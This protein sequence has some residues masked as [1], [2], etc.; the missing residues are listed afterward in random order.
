[1]SATAIAA[2]PTGVANMMEPIDFTAYICLT[3]GATSLPVYGLGRAASRVRAG[4]HMDVRESR[5]TLENLTGGLNHHRRLVDE[6]CL[7]RDALRQRYLPGNSVRLAVD[8][9]RYSVPAPAAVRG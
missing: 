7:R 9:W 6:S 8:F 3:P 2:Q 5:A 4:A 1:M